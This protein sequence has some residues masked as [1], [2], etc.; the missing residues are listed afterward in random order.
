MVSDE[1]SGL[2]NFRV[3]ISSSSCFEIQEGDGAVLPNIVPP[4]PPLRVEDN[5][6]LEK[7]IYRLKHLALFNMF[8]K[9][10]NLDGTSAMRGTLLFEVLGKSKDGTLNSSQTNLAPV[11]DHW[12]TL[13]AR[14]N[15]TLFLRFKNISKKEITVNFAVFNLQPLFGIEQI[16]PDRGE[17]ETLDRD[18]E[19]VIPL[20]MTYPR[21]DLG[22][23][24]VMDTR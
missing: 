15:D 11:E 22:S 2:P 12:G 16:Y 10:E 13:V 6:S 23:T 17:F 1:D 4:L 20:I 5:G 7:L 24:S 18:E 9:L 14:H 8:K 21:D 19:R 3:E